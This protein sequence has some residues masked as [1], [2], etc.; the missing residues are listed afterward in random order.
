MA[1]ERFPTLDD[2]KRSKDVEFDDMDN[3]LEQRRFEDEMERINTAM[4]EVLK[5]NER[6]KRD[7]ASLRGKLGGLTR[8]YNALVEENKALK[9]KR[10]HG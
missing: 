10:S 4:A 8:A 9:K 6:L 3:G 7:A 1:R 2:S 5:D